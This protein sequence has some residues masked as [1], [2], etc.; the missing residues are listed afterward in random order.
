MGRFV[1]GVSSLGKESSRFIF[2]CDVGSTVPRWRRRRVYDKP[3][4]PVP[5]VEA[6]VD[7]LVQESGVNY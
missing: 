2:A 4:V 7:I 1:L 6:A 3:L 5:V